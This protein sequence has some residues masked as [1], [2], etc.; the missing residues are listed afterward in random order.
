M[1]LFNNVHS[2]LARHLPMVLVS[3]QMLRMLEPVAAGHYQTDILEIKDQGINKLAGRTL[4]PQM[5]ILV[6]LPRQIV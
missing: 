5:D 1:A 3:S 2:N 6:L 4:D